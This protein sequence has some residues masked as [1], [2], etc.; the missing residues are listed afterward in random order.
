M[1]QKFI[2][3]FPEG[4]TPIDFHAWVATLTPLEKDEFAQALARQQSFRNKWIDDGL[5]TMVESGY[6]WKDEA[7]LKAGKP[8]D[9]VWQIYWNRWQVETGVVFTTELIEK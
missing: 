1:T 5:L 3:T 9:A 4:V 6:E 7:T 8:V 2:Y